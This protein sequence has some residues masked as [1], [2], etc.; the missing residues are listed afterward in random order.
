MNKKIVFSIMLLLSTTSHVFRAAEAIETQALTGKELDD[1]LEELAKIRNGQASNLA[2]LQKIFAAEITALTA[3][4]KDLDTKISDKLVTTELHKKSTAELSKLEK[5]RDARLKELTQQINDLKKLKDEEAKKFSRR[6]KAKREEIIGLETKIEETKQAISDLE[7]LCK[8]Q[9]EKSEQ[10]RL[11]GL[12]V[13]QEL[14][15]TKTTRASLKPTTFNRLVVKA[16]EFVT[17]GALP[18]ADTLSIETAELKTPVA[19][20]YQL[21]TL[22]KRANK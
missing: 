2:E 20:Q 3:T 1:R 22:Y 21:A 16:R 10:A 15:R 13:L 19:D 17:G 5:E 12:N 18:D 8:N 14:N 4:I 9:E 7:A 11:A 6:T